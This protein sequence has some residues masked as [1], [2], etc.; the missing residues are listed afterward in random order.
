MRN[1]MQKCFGGYKGGLGGCWGCIIP[2]TTV[3]GCW[4]R[5]QTLADSSAVSVKVRSLPQCLMYI[6]SHAWGF[7]PLNTS[8]ARSLTLPLILLFFLLIPSPLHSLQI[9]QPTQW[10]CMVWIKTIEEK[11]WGESHGPVIRHCNENNTASDY[12]MTAVQQYKD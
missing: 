3:G 7:L 8:S 4:H 11:G 9:K 5:S 12:S 2:V 6:N 1:A 10:V